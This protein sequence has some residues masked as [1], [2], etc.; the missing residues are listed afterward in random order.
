MPQPVSSRR[1]T[2]GG[3]LAI[4][5][6]SVMPAGCD[7]GDQDRRGGPGRAPTPRP[8]ADQRLVARTARDV[9]R[10]RLAVTAAVDRHRVL[11]GP[12]GPLLRMHLAHV[13]ALGGAAG[14]RRAVGQ[15][16]SAEAAGALQ[17]I[18]VVEAAHR[19]RLEAAALGAASGDLARLFASMSAAVAQ[20]LAVLPDQL[21]DAG[22]R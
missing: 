9:V 22:P 12:L 7:L 2:L 8:D 15:E 19:H 3:L 18:R 6:G 10:T 16:R 14:R 1:A 21:S 17:A 5:A 20:H 11:A 13:R 4:G